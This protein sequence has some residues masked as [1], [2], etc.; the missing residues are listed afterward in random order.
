[1]EGNWLTHYGPIL[2]L[3]FLRFV[4]KFVQD[5]LTLILPMNIAIYYNDKIPLEEED[6]IF[7][8]LF[9]SCMGLSSMLTHILTNSKSVD[10]YQR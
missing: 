6:V 3:L 9:Y 2:T 5:A 7:V 1:M 8:C 4:S 10:Q